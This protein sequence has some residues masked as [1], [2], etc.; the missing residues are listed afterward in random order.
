MGRDAKELSP[1]SH[2]KNVFRVLSI[3]VVFL[4]AFAL[5]VPSEKEANNNA[6]HDRQDAQN[7]PIKKSETEQE[8]TIIFSGQDGLLAQFMTA[9]TITVEA[10]EYQQIAPPTWTKEEVVA[11]DITGKEYKAE[12]LKNKKLLIPYMEDGYRIFFYGQFNENNV[13]DGECLLNTYGQNDDGSAWVLK[14][15]TLADFDGG[16]MTSYTQIYPDE[17]HGDAVW[18]YANRINQGELAKG[19]TWRYL[20]DGDFTEKIDYD[21]PD[22]ALLLYPDALRK[23]VCKRLI[24]YYY[25]AI[26]PVLQPNGTSKYLYND[27]SGEAYSISYYPTT[28]KVKTI[29]RGNFIKGVFSDTTG[30][31]WS[32]SC[33]AADAD[34]KKANYMFYQGTYI[35]GRK[36][37][38]KGEVAHDQE[39]SKDGIQNYIHG[40]VFE[41]M[42]L[43]WDEEY[44]GNNGG[45]E[46]TEDYYH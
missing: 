44:M 42:K 35:D 29:Y 36:Q 16:V 40:T 39:L 21:K 2:S 6:I 27:T 38:G 24:H 15:I 7:T 26:A 22:E 28:G 37:Y 12:D 43:P 8:N 14:L 34:H 13:W 3:V 23:D 10:A 45:T 5:G 46:R 30:K 25:G 9:H 31:A 18:T 32:I 4:F 33:Q 11:K 41:D 1:K 20:R 17:I 19:E